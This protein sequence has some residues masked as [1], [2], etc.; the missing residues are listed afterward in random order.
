M[1]AVVGAVSLVLRT[2]PFPLNF[3]AP[4]LSSPTIILLGIFLVLV[5]TP[6]V[7]LAGP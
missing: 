3:Y 7:P 6:C 2:Q 5:S 4:S 1:E